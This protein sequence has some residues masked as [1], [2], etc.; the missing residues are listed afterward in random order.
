MD[1]LG[2]DEEAVVVVNDDSE[3]EQGRKGRQHRE[4]G[5]YL[6]R[7]APNPCRDGVDGPLATLHFRTE[8][9]QL[10]VLSSDLCCVL[11]PVII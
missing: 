3:E 10:I 5:L 4:K 7:L 2:G 6:G 11:L 8:N 9:N 1:K